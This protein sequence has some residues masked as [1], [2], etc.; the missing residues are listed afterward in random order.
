MDPM[1]DNFTLVPNSPNTNR[2]QYSENNSFCVSA[3]LGCS[4]LQ[5][6]LFREEGWHGASEF[7]TFQPFVTLVEHFKGPDTKLYIYE[8]SRELHVVRGE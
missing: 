2:N 3:T 8:A 1:S 7:T 4:K 6:L 5:Y